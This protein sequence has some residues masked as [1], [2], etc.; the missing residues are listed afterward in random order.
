M[1][2]Q[3]MIYGAN[4]Y[5]GQLLAE[6]AKKRLLTPILA[7][8]N[9][10]EI[11]GIAKRLGLDFRVFDCSDPDVMALQLKNIDLVL[12]SA[13]PF[14][15]TSKPMVKACIKAKAHYL[16]ITGEIPVF[17]RILSR[18]QVFKEA[19]IVAIPGVGFDVVPTDC[20]AALLKNMLPD[21]TSLLLAIQ[22]A[23]SPSPGTLKTITEG[24]Y[25]GAVIRKG[26]KLTRVSPTF[27]AQEL[28]YTNGP[29]FSALVPWGDLSTAYYSTGIP[30][31]QTF[32][33]VGRK[34]YRLIQ[35]T[36]LLRPLL[37][38]PFLQKMIKKQIEKKVAGPSIQERSESEFRIFGQ[39]THS[40]G[41][42]ARLWLDTPNGYDFT[43]DAALASVG[44]VLDGQVGP[45]SWTPSQA[46]GPDFVR[47]LKGVR[48]T[49]QI[50]QDPSVAR[51]DVV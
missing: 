34:N 38:L 18:S 25:V 16:D 51:V 32:F 33:A 11:E 35:A 1:P 19:G 3:W 12:H 37:I 39:V 48:I 50:S 36:T 5:T 44:R 47:N 6:E 31:I 26:G 9:R 14:S 24:L 43:V 41:K 23:G 13:G 20:L 27:N 22:I 4:G 2:K 7:G 10:V 30:D 28:P 8:R 49:D 45:G 21:A 40:S 42:L 46:F 15:A 29:R 17:E